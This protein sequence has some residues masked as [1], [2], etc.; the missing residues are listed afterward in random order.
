[1]M[2]AFVALSSGLVWVR[3]LWWSLVRP[4]LGEIGF[5]PPATYTFTGQLINT[6]FAT[7]AVIAALAGLAALHMSLPEI[8]RKQYNWLTAPFYPRDTV[9]FWR[10]R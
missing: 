10:M 4:A 3:M 5:M 7:G 1:M 2:S 9:L 8:D 6:G